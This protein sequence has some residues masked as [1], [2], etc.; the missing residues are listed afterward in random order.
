MR[1]P[2]DDCGEIYWIVRLPDGTHPR[3]LQDSFEL[4]P[5]VESPEDLLLKGAFGRK[6][7]FSQLVTFHRLNEPLTNN[8]YAL[9]TT[10]TDF[11]P[12]QFK[13]LLKF[14]DSPNQRMLIAD[15]VGLGKTIE[16]GL[17][18]SELRARTRLARVLIIC[19]AAL[20]KKW[21]WEMKHR[22]SEEFDLYNADDFLEFLEEY[23][24]N[25]G[26]VPLR[27]I[28]S[29]QGIRRREVL[30]AFELVDPL[31][32]LVVV[33]EAHHMRN[34][35]TLTHELGQILSRSAEALLLLTATPVQTSDENLFNLLSVL[36]SE[37]FSDLFV[38]REQ[39]AANEPVIEASCALT[40]STPDLAACRCALDRILQMD[41]HRQRWFKENPTWEILQGLLAEIDPGDQ[42]SI[43]ELRRCTA[44]LS[45][46]GGSITRTRKREVIV[47]APVRKPLT[48]R[49]TFT[50][51]EDAFYNQITDYIREQ[52]PHCEGPFEKFVLMMPQRRAASCIPATIEHYLGNVVNTE[53]FEDYMGSLGDEEPDAAQ[54]TMHVA[55]EI[56]RIA[57]EFKGGIRKDSKYEALLQA[58]RKLKSETKILLFS[59]FPS[60]LEYL[61]TRLRLDGFDNV[62]IHGKVLASD[63]AERVENFR[64]DASLRVLLSSEVGS[65][66]LDFQ[67]CSVL[68]NYDLP[69]NP[70]VVEQ[71][72]GRLDR[73]GQKSETVTI[74][75]FS[76]AGTID[77]DILER[78]YGLTVAANFEENLIWP[79]DIKPLERSTDTGMPK[80]KY[81]DRYISK[82]M[83]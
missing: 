59:T 66:G 25:Q 37:R 23:R 81:E 5:A 72:I 18:L 9:H 15:E 79:K 38:F 41:G 70:M 12:H 45:L 20:R 62:V 47:N 14:L 31:F 69:W 80:P 58:L 28:T 40:Q 65:E 50:E 22:F 3:W 2:I 29:M 35:Q 49:V 60:T 39:I 43:V 13:P 6:L 1:G 61:S 52:Y 32:D 77:G 19:P 71:R 34:K 46:L 75:N 26:Q 83:V 7:D 17:I 33:D 8:I 4:V 48:E 78:L 36:D 76:V 10:R 16:A 24:A 11:Y 21:Q 27:C 68:V 55:A 63:R 53:G 82:D 42:E 30:E 54:S 44:E 74:I 67:F 57:N 64:D 56:R 73:L 51:E